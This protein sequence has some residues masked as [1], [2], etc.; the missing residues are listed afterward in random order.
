MHPAGRVAVA[1]S[2]HAIGKSR[3]WRRM[4]LYFGQSSIRLVSSHD[5]CGI[6]SPNEDITFYE[7][8]LCLN[9]VLKAFN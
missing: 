5:M 8:V 4:S 3:V 1:P 7:E 9:P 2:N 6:I